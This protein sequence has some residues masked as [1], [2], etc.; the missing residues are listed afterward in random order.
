MSLS[1]R[2]FAALMRR[3]DGVQ[4][5][6]YGD[7]KARLFAEIPPGST[8]VEIGPG[9]GVNLPHLPADVRY[10]GVEPNPHMHPP[11]RRKAQALGMDIE[12]HK[13]RAEALPLPD[14]CAD[15]VISTL[16]L[17]SVDDVAGALAE[18]RRVLRPERQRGSTLGVRPGGRFFFIEHVSAAEGTARR[19]VQQFI[20]PAWR[21][22]AD[23]CQP[24]QPTG[25]RIQQAGFAEVEMEQFAAGGVLNPVRPHVAGVAWR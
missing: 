8:V 15:A 22:L 4:E 24:D 3:S 25:A 16:V 14:A 9:T 1:Q 23:G 18:V 17:C 2:Y 12:M 20:K 5:R 7:R 6:R 10:A 11:L 21:R 13:G 19:R